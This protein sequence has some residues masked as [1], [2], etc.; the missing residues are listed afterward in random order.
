MFYLG[1]RFMSLRILIASA[2]EIAHFDCEFHQKFHW[3]FMINY[4]AQN[5]SKP[6]FVEKEGTE[7]SD[8]CSKESM[9]VI[10]PSNYDKSQ[11]QN[12][13]SKTCS[14]QLSY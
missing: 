3:E 5:A 10:Y 1:F 4:E 12:A 9:R 6:I 13:F 11:W 14:I 8:N 2:G 7:T